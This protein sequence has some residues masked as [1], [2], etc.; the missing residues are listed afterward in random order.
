MEQTGPRVE[1]TKKACHGTDL[2]FSQ[3]LGRRR[4]AG[5]RWGTAGCATRGGNTT[6]L[7]TDPKLITQEFPQSISCVALACVRRGGR[8]LAGGELEEFAE[9][10]GGLVADGIRAPL[11]ALMCRAQVVVRAVQADVQIPSAFV[12]GLAATRRA[13]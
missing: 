9:V 5:P 11:A 2:D 7:L 8:P 3:A 12:A 13:G 10:R 1:K 4:G 6:I